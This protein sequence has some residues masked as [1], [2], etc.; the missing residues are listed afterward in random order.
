MFRSIFA[1]LII[2]MMQ[3]T[4]LLFLASIFMI[5]GLVKSPYW[6]VSTAFGLWIGYLFISDY[7]FF[8][9]Y[10]VTKAK[11]EPEHNLVFSNFS[12][13]NRDKLLMPYFSSASSVFMRVGLFNG[14]KLLINENLIKRFS[15]EE[16]RAYLDL[17]LSYTKTLGSFVEALTQRFYFV[18]WY[19]L[20]IIMNLILG[21]VV[22]SYFLSPLEQIYRQIILLCRNDF[23]YRG[24]FVSTLPQIVFKVKILDDSHGKIK[25]FCFSEKCIDNMLPAEAKT[26][27]LELSRFEPDEMFR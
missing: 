25:L 7:I 20:H 12:F 11:L 15:T 8:Y 19:P 24:K 27:P 22:A 5:S 1:L 17:E 10:K 26:D 21:K 2:L 23:H 14:A 9:T 3:I 16:I 4:Y 13:R 18:S 6:A